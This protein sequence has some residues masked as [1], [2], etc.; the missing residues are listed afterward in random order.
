M[1]RHLALILA[2]VVS[3]STTALAAG[4]GD[5]PNNPIFVSGTRVVDLRNTSGHL[6]RYTTIPTASEFAKHGGTSASCSFTADGNGTTS[7]GQRYSLNQRVYSRRWIFVES[8]IVTGD[9][10]SPQQSRGPLRTAFRTCTATAR[11]TSSDI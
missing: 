1:L 3:S 10:Y 11:A 8:Q 4:S 5:D 7:D 6:A 2:L 9:G